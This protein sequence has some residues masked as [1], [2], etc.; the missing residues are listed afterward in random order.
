MRIGP[1]V[2]LVV[3]MGLVFGGFAVAGAL[4]ISGAVLGTGA[5]A[6]GAALALVLRRWMDR[7]VARSLARAGP[8]GGESARLEVSSYTPYRSWSVIGTVTTTAAY[9]GK[10]FNMHDAKRRMGLRLLKRVGFGHRL[11]VGDEEFSRD[12]YV[13]YNP[14][15][16]AK[17]FASAECR[18]AARAIFGMGFFAIEYRH[19]LVVASRHGKVPDNVAEEVRPHLLVLAANT[20]V[21]AHERGQV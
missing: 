18:E 19:G 4:P 20:G 5:A 8:P 14:E 2:G 6:G 12:V 1:A 3:A 9:N 16:G 7:S 15:I 21:V 10:R 13:E 11:D 17:L